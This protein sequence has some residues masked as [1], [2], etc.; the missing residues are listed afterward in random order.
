MFE[1]VGQPN[2]QSYFDTVARLLTSDGV[3]V[4]HAIGRK[5]EPGVTNPWIAKYIFPGGYI[6]ALSE[7][8]P[9]IERAGLWVTD[10]EILRL[11]YAQTLKVW[12]ERFTAQWDEIARQYDVRFCRMFEFYLAV[13]EV[14]FRY[15]GHMVFQLQLARAVDAVPM[16]RN[17]VYD[18]GSARPARVS[19][20]SAVRG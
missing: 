4:I 11:H 10:V 5:D 7:V 17:Y 13:S 16:T 3:A 2:Y 19:A 14:A 1:H 20:L 6:P 15:G 18:K 12:R 9:A 8:M